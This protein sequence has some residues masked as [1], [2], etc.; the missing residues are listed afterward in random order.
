M[1]P[2]VQLAGHNQGIE[3]ILSECSFDGL[4]AKHHRRST[5]SDHLS[6]SGRSPSHELPPA[7]KFNIP[8][9]FVFRV[10]SD[11]VAGEGIYRQTRGKN[12]RGHILL[13]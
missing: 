7:V 13:M 3:V 9:C 11:L 4:V 6:M 1:S 10:H 8:P 2:E 12:L 5:T